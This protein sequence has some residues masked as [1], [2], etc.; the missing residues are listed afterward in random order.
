MDKILNAQHLGMSL[1]HV[2]L[3]LAM[4]FEL[5]TTYSIQYDKLNFKL[6]SQQKS[7]VF[8]SL[9]SLVRQ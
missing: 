2:R 1:E 5:A 6:Q 9:E 4:V 3:Q 7:A 8:S